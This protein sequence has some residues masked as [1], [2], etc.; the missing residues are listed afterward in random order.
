MAR[1]KCKNFNIKELVSKKCYDYYIKTLGY[2]EDFL[3]CFFDEDILM[4]L[5]LI[6]EIWGKAI[7]INNWMYGGDLHQCGLRCNVDPIVS[8]KK[9]PYLS[10][11]CLAKGFDLHDKNG[12]NKG[13]WDCACSL[14]S[15]GKLRKFKRVEN[16]RSTP[17]WCHIDGLGTVSGKL[18]I[19]N[20]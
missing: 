19:F 18:E 2:K 10:G 7:I 6:R 15:N 1:Y 11:H 8:A 14:I 16:F 9:Y 13:L 5:D 12:D 17:T 4:D 20:V 3:W